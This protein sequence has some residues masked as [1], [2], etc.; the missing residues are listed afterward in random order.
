MRK[1][2]SAVLADRAG[3]TC[4]ICVIAPE[5]IA[6][7]YEPT[8]VDFQTCVRFKQIDRNTFETQ[9]QAIWDAFTAEG[10]RL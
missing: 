7:A 8:V 10:E 6:L 9:L 2:R 3:N 4:S 5:N 1:H